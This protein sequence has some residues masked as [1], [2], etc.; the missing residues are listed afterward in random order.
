MENLCIQHPTDHGFPGYIV[1]SCSVGIDLWVNPFPPKVE[2][3]RPMFASPKLLVQASKGERRDYFPLYHRSGVGRWRGR[4]LFTSRSL[5]KSTLAPPQ[6]S[7][8]SGIWSTP[9]HPQRK[10]TV[11]FQLYAKAGSKDGLLAQATNHNPFNA[12]DQRQSPLTTQT[13]LH[14]LSDPQ[15]SS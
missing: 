14:L 13:Q 6:V 5:A 1:I 4:S 3:K 8:A 10:Q 12:A 2:N 7:R 15:Q 9:F 11:S